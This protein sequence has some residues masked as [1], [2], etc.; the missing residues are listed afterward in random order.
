VNFS[1]PIKGL[2]TPRNEAPKIDFKQAMNSTMP[3][4]T[5]FQNDKI[6]VAIR[7]R[8]L[9]N[10]DFGKEDITIVGEDGVSIQITDG[11]H[12][13]KS[14]YTKVFGGMNNTQEEIYEFAKDSISQVLNGFNCTIFAY[15]QTGSGKTYTMFGPQWEES[16]QSTSNSLSDYL[17]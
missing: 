1:E 13:V 16:I 17:K 14:Q 12:L 7:V 9:L 11:I 2:L 8:P 15:G 5:P 6:K 10:K 3:I 4:I